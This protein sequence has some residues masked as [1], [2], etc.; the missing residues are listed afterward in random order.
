M[1][2]RTLIIP[3]IH[4]KYRIAEQIIAKEQPDLTVFLGDYFDD[5]GDSPEITDKTA[6]WLVESLSHDTIDGKNRRGKKSRRIHLIGNHDLHYMTKNKNFQCSGYSEQKWRVINSHDIDWSK[7][8]LYYWLGS[9]DDGHASNEDNCSGNHAGSIGCNKTSSRWLCTHAGFS[10][11][12]FMQQRKTYSE[13]VRGV[14]QRAE[15][16]L[17]NVH[18]ESM[19]HVFLHAG[20]VRGG[21][22]SVG[23]LVWCDYAEFDDIPN[24]RQIFGHTRDFKVRHKS[25]NATSSEHYCIDTVLCDYA[26][27]EDYNTMTIKSIDW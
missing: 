3:D 19:G 7:L 10:N 21:T 11:R 14:L 9:E 15:E 27:C 1:A 24:T 25:T 2:N 20:H 5:F 23:G 4:H 16:D 17:R 8:R 13:T 22:N 6:K 18:N 26:I 12:L